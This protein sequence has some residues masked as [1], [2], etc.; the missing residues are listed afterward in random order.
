MALNRA[1]PGAPCSLCQRVRW[2]MV[3]PRPPKSF[4][5]S[6][7]VSVRR[8]PLSSPAESG[9]RQQRPAPPVPPP[10]AQACARVGGGSAGCLV[11]G[12]SAEER[13][14]G[15]GLRG[16][17]SAVAAVTQRWEEI[18]QQSV[19]V[20]AVGAQGDTLCLTASEDATLCSIALPVWLLR[21][22]S[23]AE[24][25]PLPQTSHKPYMRIN[26][27]V[28]RTRTDQKPCGSSA[29]RAAFLAPTDNQGAP[30]SPSV[31]RRPFPAQATVLP[32]NTRGGVHV[33]RKQVP[34]CVPKFLVT[35]RP[36]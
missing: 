36:C 12:A 9:S 20:A 18:R 21:I 23:C 31:P 16:S 33:R 28:H 5:F 15:G 3:P 32:A 11:A 22:N 17:G 29:R 35:Q 30:R 19:R 13:L 4:V 1:C 26:I 10:S 2:R 6:V 25:C 14:R 34:S 24:Q 27:S 7:K 8:S